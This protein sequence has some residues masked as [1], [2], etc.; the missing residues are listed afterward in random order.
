[1]DTAIETPQPVPA[2]FRKAR[3]RK[4][5]LT[6]P[7]KADRLPPHSVESEQGVLGSILLSPQECIGRCVE[8]F[9]AGPEVFYDLRHRTIYEV[10]VEMDANQA[11][12]DLI[13]IQQSLKDRSQLE[14]VGG[15]AYLASLPDAVPSAANLDY[16]IKI[17]REKATLRRIL[18]ACTESV[19]KIYEQQD[20]PDSAPKI[21]DELLHDAASFDDKPRLTVKLAVQAIINE[22]EERHANPGRKRGI[23]TGFIDLDKMIGGLRPGEMFV[24]AARP[25]Q[26]KTSLM[27][28]IVDQVAIEQGVP[29]CVFTLETP[30]LTIVRRTLFARARVNGR[31]IEDG[32]ITERDVVKIVNAVGKVS[33][34]PLHINDTSS[35]SLPALRAYA[36]QMVQV[37]GVKV[38]AIDYLQ[39]MTAGRRCDNRLHELTLI[40][41]GLKALAKDLSVTIIVLA[42]LSREVEK[43]GRKPR[44]SDI[45][46]CGAIEQDADIIAMLHTPA[47]KEDDD[48]SGA[49]VHVTLCI[50]KQKDGPK[51]EVPLEFLR[52]YTRFES[53]T[54][55]HSEDIPKEGRTVYPE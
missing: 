19:A 26:G 40:S 43:L 37:H 2:D 3:Q 24:I 14:S 21:L 55:I 1:M 41:N 13:T 39:L 28:N 25:S 46:E 30:T 18:T 22:M 34:A 29:C 31:E 33:H 20:E 35:I 47:V 51:G 45:R 17:V 52:A 5:R 48:G 12:I 49:T 32:H 50:T 9:R 42:Q 6:D 11:P 38:I 53:A 15:L 27:M 23:Q 8:A 44:M 36:K 16:Y 7:L 4:A 54:K 10:I